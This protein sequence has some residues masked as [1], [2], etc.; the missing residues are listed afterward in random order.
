[1]MFSVEDWC[2]IYLFIWLV[3]YLYLF[4]YLF[5]YLMTHSEH[6]INGCIY[7]KHVYEKHQADH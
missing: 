1:M 6:F 3:V 5:I 7:I 4:I 2:Y